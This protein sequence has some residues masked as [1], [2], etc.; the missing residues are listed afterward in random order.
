MLD[1]LSDI[2]LDTFMGN[3]ASRLSGY[4]GDSTPTPEPATPP[5]PSEASTHDDVSSATWTSL[6][7]ELAYLENVLVTAEG[8]RLQMPKCPGLFEKLLRSCMGTE[9]TDSGDFTDDVAAD[10]GVGGSCINVT[11]RSE[12]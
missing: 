7:H 9:D 5:R 2:F 8:L 3:P 10:S 11:L 1:Q 6:L 4:D 12:R